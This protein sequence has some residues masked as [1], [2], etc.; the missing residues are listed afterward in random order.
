MF[1]TRST[2]QR[3]PATEPRARALA[4]AAIVLVGHGT[5]SDAA[6]MG[7]LAGHA[8]ALIGRQG[9]A[10]VHL[11][12][13][14]GP[15]PRPDEVL[16]RI[17]RRPIIIVPVM[18]CDGIAAGRAVIAAFGAGHGDV[19][20]C[21]PVGIHARLTSLIAQRA[22]RAAD[23]MQRRLADAALLLIAHGSLRNPA[24]ADAACHQAAALR[25]T[26]M[27]ANVAVAF[28]AQPP[29]LSMA[30]R[31]L[32]GPIIAVGLFVATGHHGMSDVNGAL[33]DASR[34]DVT[35]L[36]PIGADPGMASVIASMIGDAA[37]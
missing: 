3:E 7:G 27:F 36:G 17:T 31:R 28:L 32:N 11:A 21:P 26:R 14:H 6:Q 19:R 35:Y 29:H 16:L 8:A 37:R 18:M 25:D 20:F 15:G 4:E 23:R 2:C 13:L 10:E 9:V 5:T 22:G 33:A 1:I 34:S 30:L 24:S 12:M